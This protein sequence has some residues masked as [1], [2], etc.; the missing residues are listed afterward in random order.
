L[1]L[2]FEGFGWTKDAFRGRALWCR[3]RK[4]KTWRI[5]K[6]WDW[7]DRVEWRGVLTVLCL[8]VSHR[9]QSHFWDGESGTLDES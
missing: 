5:G 9:L 2:L 6:A 1:I 7:V 8:G 3:L 4:Q